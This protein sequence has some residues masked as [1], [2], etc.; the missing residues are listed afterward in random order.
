MELFF[1]ILHKR[2]LKWSSFHSTDELKDTVLAFIEHWNQEVGHPFNLEHKM[3]SLPALSRKLRHYGHEDIRHG[4]A[5][6]IAGFEIIIGH[7]VARVGSTRKA[8]DL[9]EFMENGS[10]IYQSKGHDR[11]R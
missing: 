1:S 4:T 7:V 10:N 11:L 3:D 9:L 2:C 6:L 8:N 5:S